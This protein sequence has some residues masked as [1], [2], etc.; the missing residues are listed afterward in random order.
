MAGLFNGLQLRQAQKL[1]LSLT[2]QLQQAIKLLQLSTLEL[3]QEIREAVEQNPM[4]EIEDEGNENRFESLETLAEQESRGDSNDDFDPFDN[5]SSIKTADTAFPD[6]DQQISISA[7]GTVTHNEAPSGNEAQSHSA[8]TRRSQ[9]IG[10]P[11]NMFEGETSYDLHDHL[12][13][14]LDLSP[15]TGA[16][17]VIAENIIDGID[18]SG[19]LQE[20]IESITETVQE[21]FPEV[22]PEDTLSVLKLIQHYDPVAVGSRNVQECLRIQLEAMNESSERDLALNIVNNYLKELSIRDFRTLCSKLSIKEDALKKSIDLI[23]SLNPRPGHGAVKEKSDFIIPDVVVVK[24]DNGHYRAE[25][26]SD[27]IPSLRINEQYRMLA[28]QAQN[29]N[30]KKFFKS[31]LQEAN[32]FMKSLSQRNET[33]MKVASVIVEKQQDFMEYGEGSM[34]PMVLNDIATEIEMH[35][36]TVSRITTEKYIVT[37]K[38]TFE[39]KYF[40][41]SKV[42]TD[43]GGTASS[44][45]IRAR[46]KELI[47][48]EDA[49]KPLSDSKLVTMLADEGIIVARRTIAKYRESLGIA[50]SSQRKRLV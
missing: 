45:A 26:N 41:S 16:D 44:T 39:L 20:T 49:K 38:G 24:D 43:D 3:R 2:P 6:A 27:A 21:D 7:E 28:Q 30:D 37:P 35:E 40:F 32:W 42:G 22:T 19:Y 8:D 13:W 31:N 11:D 33:L 47:A 29:E 18:D 23:T 12:Y 1:G 5:D 4:L 46:I 36:S 15:L 17:R 48:K 9:A 34:H 10:D 50:P 25:L 14:Q